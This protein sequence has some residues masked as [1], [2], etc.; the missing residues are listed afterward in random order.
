MEVD[1]FTETLYNLKGNEC[2]TIVSHRADQQWDDQHK[3]LCNMHQLEG[4]KFGKSMYFFVINF[5]YGYYF[6]NDELISSK[7]F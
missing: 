4:K 6:Y 3:L 7:C 5:E 1:R 2:S